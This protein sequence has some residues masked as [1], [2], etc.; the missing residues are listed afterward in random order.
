MADAERIDEAMQRN[1]A[2][3]VDR[4]KEL[5]DADLAEAVDI[6]ELGQRSRLPLLQ[7]EDIGR[8][9]DLERRI[10]ALEEEI[11]LLRAKPLD[12]EGISRN[13]MFEMLRSLCPAD[14]AAGAARDR[15]EL[16][17]L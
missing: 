5:A 6:L 2:P 10:L 15:I 9:T 1:R 3:L 8:S 13:E 16:A 4:R 7:C 14:E 11:H 17:G 12:I